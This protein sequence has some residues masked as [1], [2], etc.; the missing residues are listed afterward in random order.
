MDTPQSRSS[1]WPALPAVVLTLG[2]VFALVSGI[3]ALA[4]PEFFAAEATFLFGSLTT[5]GWITI[6]LGAAGILAGLATFSGR[7]SARWTGVL[8]ASLGA[9]GQLFIAQAYPIWALMVMGVFFVAIYGLLADSGR[10]GVAASR[11]LSGESESRGARPEARE[12][13]SDVGE[14]GRR[15]A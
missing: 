5:W 9:L 10:A 15:A 8:V 1:G 3:T 2:G 14:R 6:V 13:L 11:G 7:E 12:P 4:R